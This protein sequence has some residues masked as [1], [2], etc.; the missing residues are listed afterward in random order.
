MA[1]KK[2]YCLAIPITEL[3]DKEVRS[4]VNI[5]TS[6]ILD[7]ECLVINPLHGFTEDESFRVSSGDWETSSV[8]LLRISDTLV[9]IEDGGAYVDLLKEKAKQYGKTVLSYDE[10]FEVFGDG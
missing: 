10:V 7:F 5:V 6:V 4:K 9:I 2:I 8:G 3:D 1:N